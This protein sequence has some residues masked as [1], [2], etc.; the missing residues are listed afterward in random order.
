MEPEFLSNFVFQFAFKFI[1]L[2][3]LIFL[4]LL[5]EKLILQRDQSEKAYGFLS[6]LRELFLES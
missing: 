4:I 1:F 5:L 2:S 6:L 3:L